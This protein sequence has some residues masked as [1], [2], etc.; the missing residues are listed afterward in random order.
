MR[1]CSILGCTGKHYKEDLCS[2]HWREEMK[3]RRGTCSV[4]GCG[5]DAEKCGWCGMHYRRWQRH[6]SLDNQP[7]PTVQERFWSKVDKDGPLPTWAPFLGPC[8]I[9]TGTVYRSK[10]PSYTDGYGTFKVSGR[11]FGAHRWSYVCLVG[12]VPASLHLDHLCRVR[13][14]VNPDHLE[15]VTCAENLLRGTGQPA[16]N[17]RKTRCKRDHPLSGDNLLQFGPDNRW[18]ACKACRR[19]NYLE[20]KARLV[21]TP[22]NL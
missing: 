10:T 4:E 3:R 12:P 22:K 20:R 14:C 1:S 6:Q 9:W 16:R 19:I 5:K 21:P 13:H 17:A 18:R 15:P 2:P 11:M 7:V 8:W